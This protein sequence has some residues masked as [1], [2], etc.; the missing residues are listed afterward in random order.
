MGLR[1]VVFLFRNIGKIN[2]FHGFIEFILS[3]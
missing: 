2:L 3:L 1:N